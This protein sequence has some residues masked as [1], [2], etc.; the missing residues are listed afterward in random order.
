[1][2]SKID[3]LLEALTNIAIGAFIALLAQLL[4]FPVI[5]KHFTLSE[6]LLTTLVFTLVSFGRSYAIRRVF[7]SHSPYQ[8]LKAKLKAQS[9]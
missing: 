6:N 1:M 7:N 3:S 5:G 8:R 2:Q 4:W 9:H